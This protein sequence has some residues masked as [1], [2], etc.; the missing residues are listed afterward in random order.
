MGKTNKKKPDYKKYK[1]SKGIKKL[2]FSK[3]LKTGEAD[4]SESFERF[5][6]KKKK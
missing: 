3:Q 6:N 2:H 5:Y 4:Y 1:G